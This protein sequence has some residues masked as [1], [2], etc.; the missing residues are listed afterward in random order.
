MKGGKIRSERD[1][2]RENGGGLGVWLGRRTLLKRKRR[3]ERRSRTRRSIKMNEKLLWRNRWE[4]RE[5]QEKE[6]GNDCTN[7]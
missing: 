6:G 5:S 2:G 3:K 7:E 4:E 1:T